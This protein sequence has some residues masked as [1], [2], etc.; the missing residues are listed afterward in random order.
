MGGETTV[1]TGLVDGLTSRLPEMIEMLGAFVHEESPTKHIP[2]TVECARLVAERGEALLGVMPELVTIDERPIVRFCGPGRRRVLLLGH[3]DTVWPLG[4]I[5][6]WPFAV[7]G[8]IATGPGTSDMKAGLV[9]G[10]FALERLG[11][12]DGVELLVTSDE[13]I[14]SPTSRGLIEEAARGLDA[15]LVLEP[16]WGGRLKVARKGCYTYRITLRGR[17]AH[18]SLGSDGGANALVALAHHV[19]AIGDVGRGDTSVT[20]TLA[21]AGTTSNTVPAHAK[22]VVD[23]RVPS[24]DEMERVEAELNALRPV[25]DGV[26]IEVERLSHGRPPLPRSASEKLFELARRVAPTVGIEDLGGMEV[27]GGSDGNL[28]AAVGTPTLD[29]LG[30]VGGG[31]HAEGEHV[32]VSTMPRRAAL[33]SALVG[34]LLEAGG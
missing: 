24:Q 6:R 17:A 25:V 27:A 32:I 19:L 4:T 23:V 5:D 3:L 29:G 9:Q 22:L 10:L 7:N 12:L 15:V 13:E 8:N 20:P 14:G 11:S 26:E 16:S 33:V 34:E 28:T 2:A 1:N 31:A 18:A 21:D 30:A